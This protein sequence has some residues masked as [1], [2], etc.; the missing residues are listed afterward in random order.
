MPCDCL[1]PTD[2][3][4]PIVAVEHEFHSLGPLSSDLLFA[5]YLMARTNISAFTSGVQV[6]IRSFAALPSCSSWD[7]SPS[8]DRRML[9]RVS[10]SPQAKTRPVS[11]SRIKSYLAPTR[12]LTTAGQPH[13]IASFTTTPKGSYSEGSTNRSDA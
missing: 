4:R 1:H 9:A 10:I 5:A 6:F 13:S 7:R 8:S 12:S 3:R 11:P 2:L